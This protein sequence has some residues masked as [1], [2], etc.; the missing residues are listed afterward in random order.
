MSTR[1]TGLLPEEKREGRKE[2]K[3]REGRI[4]GGD[5]KEGQVSPGVSRWWGWQV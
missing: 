2:G 5:R 3:R 4:K 1:R